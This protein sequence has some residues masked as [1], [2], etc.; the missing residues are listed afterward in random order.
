MD[1]FDSGMP[2]RIRLGVVRWLAF[3]ALAVGLA[4]GFALADPTSL[5]PDYTD[6]SVP[7]GVLLI[8]TIGAMVGFVIALTLRKPEAAW[9][10]ATSAMVAPAALLTIASAGMGTWFPW[11]AVALCVPLIAMFVCLRHERP[12]P[13]DT[14]AGP[15]R[16]AR[17]AS[18]VVSAVALVVSMFSGAGM[19]DIDYSGTW[20]NHEHGVTL[21]MSSSSGGRSSYTLTSGT[22][23]EEA[24]WTLDH[25]QMST[26]VQA[27]L[28]RDSGTTRCIPGPD[29]IRLRV[30]GGTVAKPVLSTNGPSGVSWVLTRQ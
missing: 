20:T 17:R 30:V 13:E 15:A 28:L 29:S 19:E 25:P 24:D 3:G 18:V 9:W 21:T 22:C 10:A 26:S 12:E 5:R 27:W 6:A 23:S 4:V 16:G 14:D 1:R 2:S 11:C 7:L 8:A